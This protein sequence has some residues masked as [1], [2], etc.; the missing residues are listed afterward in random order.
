MAKRVLIADDSATTFHQLRKILELSGDFEVAGHAVDG[1]DAVAKYKELR[2]DLVTMDIVMPGMDGLGAVQAIIAF[3]PAAKI[4]VASSM[5]GVK[6]KV[7]ALL[8]AGAKNVIVKPF[9][10]D[11]VLGILRSLG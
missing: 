2:P 6:D 4:V 1:N 3:D 8:S 5:G 10:T 9:D 7:V 11:K